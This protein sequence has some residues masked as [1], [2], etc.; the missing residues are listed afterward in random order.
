MIVTKEKPLEEIFGYLEPYERILVVG[1][2]GC[3]H[4]PRGLREAKKMEMLVSMGFRVKGREVSVRSTSIAKQCDIYN[5]RVALEPQIKDAQAI[6]T[7]A[8]SIGAGALTELFPDI[9]VFPAQNTVFMGIEDKEN[10]KF[11]EMCRAC[12]DCLLGETFGICPITRCAKSLLNGPCGGPVDGMCEYK[13]YTNKCAW[14]EIYERAKKF[15]RLDLF[16]KFRMPR[17]RRV[18]IPPRKLLGGELK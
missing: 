8:C 4:P 10:D 13:G 1:C 5:C 12:G 15:N 7:M 6:L 9:P 14:I 3:T 18:E 16:R 17:D 11:E 2:E